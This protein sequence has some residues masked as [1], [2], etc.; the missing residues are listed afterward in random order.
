MIPVEADCR[1][2]GGWWPGY[3]AA[4]DKAER[5]R[6][7]A[8]RGAGNMTGRERCG[9]NVVIEL[10]VV[11]NRPSESSLTSGPAGGPSP[12]LRK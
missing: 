12:L 11:A 8:S 9:G 4:E 5:K 2:T 7:G 10:V 6:R 3:W 1:G